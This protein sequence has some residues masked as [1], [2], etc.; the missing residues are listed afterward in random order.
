[1]HNF[2]CG[3]W[4]CQTNLLPAFRFGLEF[5]HQAILRACYDLVDE[6]KEV[7]WPTL[8]F[9][10]LPALVFANLSNRVVGSV[11]SESAIRGLLAYHLLVQ[12]LE[13]S[14]ATELARALFSFH[15]RVVV[16]NFVFYLRAHH[17]DLL[18]LLAGTLWSSDLVAKLFESLVRSLTLKGSLGLFLQLHAFLKRQPSTT[19]RKATRSINELLKKVGVYIKRHQLN[20]AIDGAFLQFHADDQTILREELGLDFSEAKPKTKLGALPGV[21]QPGVPQPKPLSKGGVA[22]H[23]PKASRAIHRPTQADRQPSASNANP[24]AATSKAA[25]GMRLRFKPG[26]RIQLLAPKRLGT[27]R[28]VGRLHFVPGT[29]VGLPYPFNLGESDGLVRGVRHFQTGP[30]CALLVKPENVFGV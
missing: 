18:Q 22:S 1:M 13:M 24:N 23:R 15:M 20:I 25:S 26:D 8:G 3:C 11:Q 27:V 7:F 5:D 16:S 19:L 2:A 17:T 4:R 28:Y 21:P 10:Q 30:R 12:K 29:W 6:R 9:N 14:R